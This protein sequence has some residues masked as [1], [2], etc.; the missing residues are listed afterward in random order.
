MHKI[1]LI[2]LFLFSFLS[3]NEAQYSRHRKKDWSYGFNVFPHFSTVIDAFVLDN[4][5]GLVPAIGFGS[6]I[7]KR[8]T[9]DICFFGGVSIVSSGFVE[10]H[11]N[12]LINAT[13]RWRYLTFVDVPIGAIF[14]LGKQDKFFVKPSISLIKPFNYWIIDK[15]EFWGESTYIWKNNGIEKFRPINFNLNLAFGRT[16]D[17]YDKSFFAEGKFYVSPRKLQKTAYY[18]DGRYKIIGL[19]LNIGFLN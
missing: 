7:E 5:N 9:R 1:I 18:L 2:A 19:G 17:I 8:H 15:F 14:K 10:N 13:R 3:E 6:I 4:E 11:W 12:V 16:F